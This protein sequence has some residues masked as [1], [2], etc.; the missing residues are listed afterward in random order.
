[1]CDTRRAEN[2]D[3]GPDPPSVVDHAVFAL[4]AAG[5]RTVEHD[6]EHGFAT[7]STKAAP[8]RPQKDRQE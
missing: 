2:E 4:A 1:M 3:L 8:M 5:Q 6:A 7:N